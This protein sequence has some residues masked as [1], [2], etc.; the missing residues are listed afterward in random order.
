[1][2]QIS[3][4]TSILGPHSTQ[5]SIDIWIFADIFTHFRCSF[6]NHTH[7]VFV[8]NFEKKRL[9]MFFLGIIFALLINLFTWFDLTNLKFLF[10]FKCFLIE[11]FCFI[12]IMDTSKPF[13]LGGGFFLFSFVLYPTFY[14]KTFHKK[15]STLSFTLAWKEFLNKKNGIFVLR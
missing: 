14:L 11:S 5:F 7:L 4:F 1:M 12:I 15:S 13:D 2:A 6:I 8:V 10:W 9:C 3:N